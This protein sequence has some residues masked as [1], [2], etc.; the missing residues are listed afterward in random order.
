M[1]YLIFTCETRNAIHYPA[2]HLHMT[3]MLLCWITWLAYFQISIPFPCSIIV[4]ASRVVYTQPIV[5][6]HSVCVC[7][8]VCVYEG[9]LVWIIPS[10]YQFHE[11]IIWACTT[12]FVHTCIYRMLDV[13]SHVY[14]CLCSWHHFL[15]MFSDLDLSK[16]MYLLD[17]RFT[18]WARH[19]ALSY[20][21]AGLFSDNPRRSCPEL[22]AWTVVAFCSWQSYAAKT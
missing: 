15:C 17:F 6:V 12:N 18:A 2:R 14:M 5:T 1:I 16:H 22:G 7:V 20:V 11:S 3:S 19:L 21:L 8:C 9:F 4:K 13:S 10:T